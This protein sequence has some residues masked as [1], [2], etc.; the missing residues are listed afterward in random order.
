MALSIS[1]EKLISGNVV[2]NQ[3][4]EYKKGW[5]PEPILH[6]ICA[7]ANDFEGYS[8]GYIVIGVDA[9]KGIPQFPI[10]G[11][12][13]NDIDRIES[14]VLEYCK[15]CITPSYVPSIEVVEYDGKKL[16]VLW[17]Y[18]G[19]DKPYECLEHVYSKES[20]TKKC[21]IR[22][23]SSTIIANQS[24]IKE[25]MRS[26]ELVPF[27]DRINRKATI[28]DLKP[29][30]I[31]EYLSNINSDLINRFDEIGFV[32]ICKSL[33]IVD[34]PREDLRPKNIGL[35]M[36]NDRP[37]KFLPYSYIVID[38]IPDPA[39]DGII[40]KEFY[41]P[42]DR[43]LKD[44]IQYIKNNYIEKKITK[45]QNKTE[46]VT[47]FNYPEEFVDEILPNAI[48]HKDYQIGEPITVR[49]TSDRI[50]VT[51]FPGFDSS[52]TDEKINNK[53]FISRKYR[54]K[55]I[56]EF[57][58]ELELIEAKNTGIPKVIRALKHNNSPELEFETNDTRE[59][60]TV[61]VKKNLGFINE[62][63]SDSEETNK[64]LKVKDRIISALS[65][66][67]MTMTE[68]ARFLDYETVPNSVKK[69]VS[70]LIKNDV[71]YR[72]DN[73]YYLK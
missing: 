65:E 38:Y 59:Y 58:R 3:R 1:I 70:T 48:L 5:D 63:H 73:K 21:Y 53:N 22:K 25:L 68:I 56:A 14:E 50:E 9:I 26:A 55:R 39:G 67:P 61:I 54:N 44:A 60:L 64:T 62:I 66:K 23:G 11:I 51:S 6:S 30:L 17:V 2:E 43:Q 15:K 31:R 57:L 29:S 35:L 33:H 49:I 10:L 69:A 42:I 12:D 8:G 20:K 24:E 28:N 16:I 37:E 32:D 47:T 19:Y 72:K 52:I 34:G 71:I 18:Q 7:F 41:G 13:I 36:F 4:I 46:S 27:D 45:I 40:T